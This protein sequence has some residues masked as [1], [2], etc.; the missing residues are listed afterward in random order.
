M[1]RQGKSSGD[2]AV[3][4]QDRWKRVAAARAVEEVEDGMVLGLGS[5]STAVFA[6]E[7]L[8]ERIVKGLRV[9]G[10]PTS[11]GTADLARRLGVPLTNFAVHRRIDLAI[12]GDRLRIAVA[13]RGGHAFHDGWWQLHCRLHHRR[14]ARSGGVGSQA[15]GDGR[16]RREWPFH[17]HSV[18]DRGRSADWR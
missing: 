3:A 17:R 16:R 7:A 11:E 6:V 2:D 14:G 10:I 18:D 9:F 13:P 4:K 1:Q 8:A 15:F 5:G 12:D